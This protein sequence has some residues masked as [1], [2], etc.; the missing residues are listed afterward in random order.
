MTIM[1]HTLRALWCSIPENTHFSLDV[2]FRINKIGIGNT[3]FFKSVTNEIL[4][5]K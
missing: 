4:H 1:V 3:A 2:D 5:G